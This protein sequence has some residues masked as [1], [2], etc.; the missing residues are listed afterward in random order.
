MPSSREPLAQPYPADRVAAYRKAGHWTQETLPQLLRSRA[1]AHPSAPAIIDASGADTRVIT[2]GELHIRAQSFGAGLLA[3]GIEPGARVVVQLPNCAEFFVALFGVVYAGLHPILALPAHRKTEIA[4]F[5][6]KARARA[7][8]VGACLDGF[9]AVAMAQEIKAETP[10]LTEVV[11]HANAQGATA[12]GDIDGDR[13]LLPPDPAPSDVALVLLSGGSTG[14]PKLIPRRHDEYIYSLRESGRICG[15][16]TTS[17]Y[18]AVLPV[19]HNF[20]LSSPGSLGIFHSGG[21]VVLPPGAAAAPCL[22]LIEHHRVTIAAVVPPLAQAWLGALGAQD[23][24][25]SCLRVLQIGGA[26]L[27]PEVARQIEPA[28]GCRLQQ[29]FGMAEGL[30]NYTR[31]DDPEDIRISTQGR[32]ISADDEIR[33]LDQTGAP[34][35]TDAPGLLHVRG[36]L[37][38]Q[39]LS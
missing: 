3:R 23:P 6:A 18:L 5:V 37:Y 21:C 29:V 8:I 10:T 28:F 27:Q 7:L 32:P 30:V 17:R 38:H 26:K 31:L 39:R 11:V 22:S 14:L 15:L 36:P 12:F 16:D 4:H 1:T 2:Y 19:G 35:G 25:L 20:T 13:A 9:D 33:I 34:V 24:D